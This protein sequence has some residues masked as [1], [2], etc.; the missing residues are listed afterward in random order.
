MIS[1]VEVLQKKQFSSDGSLVSYFG[2]TQS[3]CEKDSIAWCNCTWS[4]EF[5]AVRLDF[6]TASKSFV[7][8]Y[9]QKNNLIAGVA[10]E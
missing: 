10:I 4:I 2:R 1:S 5:Y 8:A 7:Y 3:K 6:H 9:A